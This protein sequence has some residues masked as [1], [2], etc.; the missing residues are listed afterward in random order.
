MSAAP[1]AQVLRRADELQQAGHPV[2]REMHALHQNVQLYMR[3]AAGPHGG[4][5]EA[6]RPS[7]QSVPAHIR[8][9]GKRYDFL[10][11]ELRRLARAGVAG[12]RGAPLAAVAEETPRSAALANGTPRP[13]AAG[14]S[15]AAEGGGGCGGGGGGGGGRGG[16]RGGGGGGGGGGADGAGGRDAAVAAVA[17]AR[18]PSPE[19]LGEEEEEDPMIA[20]YLA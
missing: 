11:E 8:K 3:Q 7:G 13:A 12:S 15:E 5:A 19:E 18:G 2:V 9:M 10:R 6:E 17:A 16:G 4:A 1:W 14:L 20:L